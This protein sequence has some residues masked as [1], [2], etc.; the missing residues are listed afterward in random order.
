MSEGGE[1]QSKFIRGLVL[2]MFEKEG[3]TAV[4]W[5]PSDLAPGTRFNVA[6][7]SISLLMGEATYQCG[8]NYESIKYFGILPYPDVKLT[9]LTYF[10]LISD[11]NA[12]G[13]AKASTITILID[14]INDQFLYKNIKPLS[15]FLNQVT[16]L[17]TPELSREETTEVMNDLRRKLV[18]FANRINFIPSP[19]KT[20]KILFSGLDAAGKTSIRHALDSR[21]SLLN[22]NNPTIGIQRAQRQI[23]NFLNVVEWDC[24]GQDKYREMFMKRGKSLLDETDGLFYIIDMKRP[25]RF[26][27]SISYLKKNLNLLQEINRIVPIAVLLHKVDPDTE[28]NSEM[29]SRINGVKQ[30]CEKIKGNFD[31]MYFETTIFKPITLWNAYSMLFSHI[32]P[33][34]DILKDQIKKYCNEKKLLGAVV[35]HDDKIII[36]RYIEDSMTPNFSDEFIYSYMTLFKTL[37]EYEYTELQRF[38]LEFGNYVVKYFGLPDLPHNFTVMLLFDSNSGIMEKYDSGSLTKDLKVKIEGL[39]QA[40]L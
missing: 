22:E 19:E 7:R 30:E 36:S 25:D 13:R 6:M 35:I 23:G 21:D 39:L 37:S 16:P 9:G 40:Y 14:N 28:Q 27:E 26:S 17:I 2:A 18:N 33:N 3:P 38:G 4:Y 24:G 11:N 32:S 5:Y 8:G 12:R 1:E 29:R 20:L 34:R 31:I 10:F 15:L